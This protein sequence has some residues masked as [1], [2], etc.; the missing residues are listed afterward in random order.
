V[1]ELLHPN[2]STAAVDK[3]LTGIEPVIAKSAASAATRAAG[4]GARQL[5]SSRRAKR[6]RTLVKDIEIASGSDNATHLAPD[7]LALIGEYI[8]TPQFDHIALSI[9]A[10]LTADKAGR[11]S[12]KALSVIKDELNAS[13]QTCTG[14]GSP[15]AVIDAIFAALLYAVTN[16]TAKISAREP[17]PS[18]QAESIKIAA[19]IAAASARNA[20]LLRESTAIAD[21]LNFEDELRAQIRLLHATMRIPHAGTTKQVPYD[22]LFIAP[23]LTYTIS[24]APNEKQLELELSDML[25]HSTRSVILGD[26]G[27]G[28]S[29]LALKLAYDVASD[30]VP[31]LTTRLPLLVV[32]RDYAQQAQGANRVSILEYLHNLSRTPYAI[33]PP[34]SALE[35]LLLNGRVLIIFDGLD[36]LLDTSLRRDVVQAVEG[37]AYRYPTTQIVVTSRRVGYEEAPLDADLFPAL[38]LMELDTHQVKS[39]ASKWFN[40]DEGHSPTERQRLTSSFLRDSEFV[41][42]LRVNPLMLSLMCGIYATENYIPRNRPEVYEK[43]ALL[44]FEKWDKQRGIQVPLSFDAHVYAAMRSLALYMYSQEKPQLKRQELIAFIKDYLL[45]KRFDDT[46]IAEAAAEEFIEFCK[47][48]AWVLTDVGDEKYGFTHRTFL[49]YFSA[50]QL[51]RLHTSADRLFAILHDRLG[52]REWDVVAQLALQILGRTV[53]DGADDFLNL[54]VEAAANSTDPSIKANLLSFSS[55]ALQFIVPRPKIL[56]SIVTSSIQLLADSSIKQRTHRTRDSLFSSDQAATHL[57]GVSNELRTEVGKLIQEAI[58]VLLA[59]NWRQ[60]KLL[61]FAV[62]PWVFTHTAYEEAIRVEW[63][64]WESWA[65]DNWIRLEKHINAAAAQYYWLDVRRLA[66]GEITIRDLISRHEPR[67]LYDYRISTYYSPYPP[68]AYDL[69]TYASAHLLG[70]DPSKCSSKAD[71]KGIAASLENLLPTYPSP[72]L[73]RRENYAALENALVQLPKSVMY[74]PDV[75]TL[76]LAMPIAEL[77]AQVLERGFV[78]TPRRSDKKTSQRRALDKA[79]DIFAVLS[80]RYKDNVTADEI[81]NALGRLNIPDEAREIVRRWTLS[82]INYIALPAERRSSKPHDS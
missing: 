50:N 14:I 9:A 68:I 76:F 42:D 18:A 23:R 79:N 63:T 30:N 35:Y 75:V 64:F 55:R 47:G 81:S 6:L 65:T 52:A 37:F 21:Y 28:K 15:T 12:D 33:D 61:A 29:T 1:H 8:Q 2:I 70:R 45:D 10:I 24:G 56:R 11:K 78:H 4:W 36:E 32:L 7:I 58:S 69:L 41:A 59:K 80:L 39:Y 57:F 20:R 77:G 22:Q 74:F 19:S 16:E 43:C 67:A 72:W 60:E 40:L 25:K 13:L 73:K 48:R 3:V 31:D 66:I 82:Q 44:L 34:D 26:P 53:E 49:E 17:T 5:R 46:D 62:I 54:T 38:Q 71:I 51:V 27:G